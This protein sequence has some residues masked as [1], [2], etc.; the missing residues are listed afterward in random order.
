MEKDI[1]SGDV[2]RTSE[3]AVLLDTMNLS[4]EEVQ[5]WIP[6]SLITDGESVEVG[7]KQDLEVASWFL[8][9]QELI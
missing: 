5:V 3:K 6:R 9:K 4:G 1:V 7:L 2:V 8:D